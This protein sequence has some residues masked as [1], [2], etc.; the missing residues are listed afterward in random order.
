MHIHQYAL[1][2]FICVTIGLCAP[3]PCLCM[4][5]YALLTNTHY[6]NMDYFTNTHYSHA[7]S[8]Y[9]SCFMVISD[10]TLAIIILLQF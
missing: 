8:T 2:I 7:F 4:G 5:E 6:A 9:D 10:W 1:L 3:K